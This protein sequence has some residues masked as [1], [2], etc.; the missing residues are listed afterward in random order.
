MLSSHSS[1]E[2]NHDTQGITILNARRA[3]GLVHAK[4]EKKRRTDI[5]ATIQCAPHF[6]NRLPLTLHSSRLGFGE[7]CW[8][9]KS[10]IRNSKN[11]A[12][13]TQSPQR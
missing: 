4:N 11:G 6:L 5:N 13:H 1:P 10:E 2:E 7:N 9:R 8:T 3:R 12:D